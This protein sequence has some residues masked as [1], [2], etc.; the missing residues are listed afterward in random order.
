MWL[1]IVLLG[2]SLLSHFVRPY[3]VRTARG[4][5]AGAGDLPF[6][7]LHPLHLQLRARQ[8]VANLGRGSGR[9]RLLARQR[10]RPGGNDHDPVGLVAV[11]EKG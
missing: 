2:A 4:Q 7:G 6:A 11:V 8:R 10:D 5:P 1:Q 3:V 9:C